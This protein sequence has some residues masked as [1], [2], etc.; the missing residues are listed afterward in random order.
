MSGV[1]DVCPLAQE[2]TVRA[3]QSGGV[4]HLLRAA[5]LEAG[6][7]VPPE[8][9]GVGPWV[10]SV[11]G[12]GLR[13]VASV[14]P[15]SFAGSLATVGGVLAVGA[16]RCQPGQSGMIH[17]GAVGEVAVGRRTP[18]AAPSNPHQPVRVVASVGCDGPAGDAAGRR[19]QMI[20]ARPWDGIGH[21][22]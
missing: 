12:S 16:Q 6:E 10:G 5:V 17:A 4:G 3:G 9:V 2:G 21:P 15:A 20:G 11:P 13:A 18:P 7:D 14:G 8:D 19:R 1:R 22:S